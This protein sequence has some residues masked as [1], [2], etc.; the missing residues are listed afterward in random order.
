MGRLSI[1]IGMEEGSLLLEVW[2]NGAGMEPEEIVKILQG[3]DRRPDD[4]YSIGI[5]NVFSRLTLHF[6][7]QCK[8]EMDSKP[9]VYTRT[10]ILI[11]AG[12]KQATLNEEESH[13]PGCNR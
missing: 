12:T 2:D 9:G 10:R 4:N 8:M 3:K 6:K 7:E 1:R 5:E 11:P 13:E